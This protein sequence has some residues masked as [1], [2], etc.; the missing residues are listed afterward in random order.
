M[1]VISLL[2]LFH[3]LEEGEPLD[4]L[5]VKALKETFKVSD[6]WLESLE[7]RS[8]KDAV[9]SPATLV[10]DWR[11]RALHKHWTSLLHPSRLISAF[12]ETLRLEIGKELSLQELAGQSRSVAALLK[13]LRRGH[14]P[15]ASATGV[16]VSTF[17]GS[18]GLEFDSVFIVGCEDGVIPH[19]KSTSP[20]KLL[21]ERRALYV[22]LTRASHEVIIT[23]VKHDGKRKRE[24]SRFLPVAQKK[25]WT[26]LRGLERRFGS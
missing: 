22:A 24:L 14:R 20:D 5:S 3:D 12:A 1:Q 19:Y 11:W 2:Q 9:E 25:L 13:K 7:S 16:L 21:E 18:K 17:H 8:I 23:A 6:E 26:E 4:P 10:E 15:T